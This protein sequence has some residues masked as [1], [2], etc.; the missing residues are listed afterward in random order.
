MTEIHVGTL[1]R[2]DA[3]ELADR[4]VGHIMDLRAPHAV[5]ID[6]R[7]TVTIEPY[8]DAVFEDVVGVYAPGG[9]LIQTYKAVRD[10]LASE[11]ARRGIVAATGHRHKRVAA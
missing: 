8:D 10:D 5:C 7:G 2:F 6:P 9:G 11:I 3:R 4:A 1:A